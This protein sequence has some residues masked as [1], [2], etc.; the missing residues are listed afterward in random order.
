MRRGNIPSHPHTVR[1]TRFIINLR[2][3]RAAAIL[4]DVR[5]FAARHDAGIAFT[6]RPRHAGELATQALADGCELVVAVGGDGTMNEIA[7]VLTGTPATLGFVPCGSGDGLALHLGISRHVPRALQLLE[8][9][10][11]RPIDTGE[12]NGLPFFSAT[13]LGFEAEVAQRFAHFHRRGLPGYLR[14][15]LRLFFSHRPETLLLEH[16]GER[17]PVEVFTLAVQNC[18]QLGNNVLSAPE[19][20]VDDGQF[21]LVAVPPVNF[22]RALCLAARLFTGSFERAPGITR[23]RSARFAIER[24]APGLI[25][26]D[27]E[28]HH[29]AA[30]L[31]ITVRPRSLRVLAP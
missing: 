23:R 4:H 20:A 29:A 19:A 15:G 14:A 9:G 8:E 5:V 18:N 1:K 24:P 11:S 3:G 21:D 31:E 7:T 12:I 17:G 30:R 27:G 26:T 2:A 10:R 28:L 25:H 6:A 16:D 22:L 13:G